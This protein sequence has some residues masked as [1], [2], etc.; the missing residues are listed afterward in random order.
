MANIL[1]VDSEPVLL[2]LISNTLR[3]DGHEVS[4]VCSPLVALASHGAG[5]TPIDLLLTDID[6]K[7]ISGFELVN[8]LSKI[9]F[10]GSV[11]FMSEYP[12]LVAVVAESLGERAILEK[13]FTA[14]QLRAAIANA[15]RRGKAKAP[16]A[17]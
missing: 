11:L 1:L 8:R 4:A 10:N 12:S 14:A 7:P 9:G 3:L 16:R 13:P 5:Q 6:L 15:L 17:A 2:G